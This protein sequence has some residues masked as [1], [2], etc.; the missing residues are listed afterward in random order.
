MSTQG[1]TQPAETLDGKTLLPSL[2]APSSLQP[3]GQATMPPSG[4][5]RAVDSPT[6]ALTT[7]C[8]NCLGA[9]LSLA[10]DLPFRVG[11]WVWAC[12]LLLSQGLVQ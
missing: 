2:L 9:A 3:Q 4:L 12:S 6:S 11:T 7:L 1:T 10:Q 8:L 5:P